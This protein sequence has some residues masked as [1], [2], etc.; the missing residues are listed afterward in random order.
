MKALNPKGIR[1]KNLLESL[2]SLIKNSLIEL[3]EEEEL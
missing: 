3:D 2:Q 1:E